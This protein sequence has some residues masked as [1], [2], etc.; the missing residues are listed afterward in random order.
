MYFLRRNDIF[1]LIAI[2]IVFGF[3]LVFKYFPISEDS[4][5][6]KLLIESA[7]GKKE[8][9]VAMDAQ[10]TLH[11]HGPLGETTV[12]VKNGKVWVVFSPCPDKTCVKMGKIPDNTDFIACVPNR[13]VIRMVR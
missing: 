6:Y 1:P 8:L 2:G 13:V 10:E 7:E 12:M 9:T 3:L 5:S 11:L 4:S